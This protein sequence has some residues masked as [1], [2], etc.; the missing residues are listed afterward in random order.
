MNPAVLTARELRS[1]LDGE[2]PPVVLDVREADE[3]AIA[4][5]PGAVHL[6]LSELENALRTLDPHAEYVVV[7]HHGV[8]SARAAALMQ[9]RGF[10][11]VYNLLGGIDAWSCEIDPNVPRY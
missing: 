2:S 9:E 5:L 4:H 8:R 3:V 7:C 11:R 1:R 6:P 10:T